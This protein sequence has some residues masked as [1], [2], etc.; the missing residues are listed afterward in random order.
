MI[1]HA[2]NKKKSICSFNNG[3]DD[4]YILKKKKELP[5][6]QKIFF[7]RISDSSAWFKFKKN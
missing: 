2:I 6:N 5:S 4:E 3:I 7:C 1:T